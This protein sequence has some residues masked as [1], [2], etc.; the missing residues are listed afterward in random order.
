MEYVYAAMLLHSAGKTIDDKSITGVLEAAGVDVDAARVKGL[1]AS[2]AS[3]DIEEAMSTAIAAPVA[4]APAAGGSGG[5]S[6]AAAPVE[7]AAAEEEEEDD[8][9]FEGL[10][11]LF[12]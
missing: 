4:A 6:E 7:E 2:L 10:G 3:V 9:G 5:G 8:S 12:G 11:S 1:V